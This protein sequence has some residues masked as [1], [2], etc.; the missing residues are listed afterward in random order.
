V[1]DILKQCLMSCCVSLVFALLLPVYTA[2]AQ[3]QITQLKEQYQKTQFVAN[4]V[5][6]AV[7]VVPSGSR[8]SEALNIVQ[9]RVRDLTGSVLPVLSAD[10]LPKDLLK[11][12][13][14]IALG[15]IATSA[16]IE[17][18]YCEW[19]VILDL[20]YPGRGGYVVRSLHN[21]YGTGKN[22]IFLGGSDDVG[23]HEAAREFSARLRGSAVDL[24]V[25]RLMTIRLGAGLTPPQIGAQLADW[26]VLSWSDSRRKTS[27]GVVTGYDPATYF[28]WN[29]ISVAGILYYMTGDTK[30]LQTF[31]ELALPNTHLVPLQN[32]RDEAFSDPLDPL[33]KSHHYRSHLVDRVF[34]LIEESPGFSDSERLAITQKLFMHQMELDPAHTYVENNPDRHALWHLLN[35][36]SGSMYF[37]VSYP[38]PVWHRRLDNVRRSFQSLIHDPTWGER[39]TLEWVSTS[40]E[41]VVDFFLMDGSSE[42]VASGTAKTLMQG[43]EALMSGEE[44]DDYNK[45]LSLG[46][47]SKA[48]YLLKDP[49]YIWMAQHLGVDLNVFRIGQS[50][51]STASMT[52][53]PPTDLAG[54]ITRVPVVQNDLSAANA[55]VAA[56]DAFQLLSYRSGLSATDDYWL[57]D[58]FEGLGR[59][60]FQLNT[61]LSLR[62]FGGKSILSGYANDLSIWRNGMTE[63]RVARSAALKQHFA[64][65]NFAYVHSAVPDM[66]GAGWDRHFVYVRDSLALVVD[67]V[68]PL[69]AGRFDIV[70]SWQLGGAVKESGEMFRSCQTDNGIAMSSVDIPLQK[71]ASNVVQGKRSVDLHP[72]QTRSQATVFFETA[73]P[74]TFSRLQHG[75]YLFGGSHT[76]FVA[77]GPLDREDIS[78]EAAFVY[79]DQK[80]IF[81]AHATQLRLQGDVLFHSDKPVNV[82]WN[83]VGKFL[84][85]AAAEAACIQFLAHDKLNMS[86]VRSPGNTILSAI[87]PANL[88]EHIASL[89]K[90]SSHDIA[91]FEDFSTLAPTDAGAPIWSIDLGQKL[92]GL[93]LAKDSFWTASQDGSTAILSRF[94]QNGRRLARQTRRGEML[95]LFPLPDALRANNFSV[96]AGFKDDTLCAYAEDGREVWKV[97]AAIHPS[98]RIGDHYEAPWFTNPAEPDNMRGILSIAVDDFWGNGEQLIALGRPC[99]VEFRTLNGDLKA[100]VPTR[101][102]NNTALA[103]LHGNHGMN[104]AMVL[105][106]KAY[107]GNPRLSGIDSGYRNVGDALFAA[108]LPGFTDMHAWLQRGM[109]SLQVADI[110]DDGK[111]EVIYTLS[112]HWNELRVYDDIGNPLWT[113]FFGPDKVAG[114]SS[115]MSA[116]SLIDLHERKGRAVI[117]GTRNGWVNAFDSSGQALWQHQV[118]GGVTCMAT[119]DEK[120]VLIVGCDDGALYLFDKI[121]DAVLLGRMKGSVRKIATCGD[122]MVVGSDQGVL[123]CYSIV[124]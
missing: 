107:T 1:F 122:R 113:K 114:G 40:I 17:R 30:Y 50:Y 74:A 9:A 110:N 20:K 55:S 120:G 85:V 111:D 27:H 57:L 53:Q 19:Q 102:G 77:S 88:Q 37:S 3:L 47:L 90:A 49:R 72:G 118:S 79:V 101:W 119:A 80:Q 28:G 109:A 68:N 46:L 121:G 115:F 48:S 15:N 65:N 100:S 32:S 108:I 10:A 98:F 7:I 103:V 21:P 11:T 75:G 35:I 18:L 106:G 123:S 6:E 97:T 67:Q 73:H 52:G 66:S 96:L 69:A 12:R 8:Y 16:F 60:P 29:P 25:D 45:Y 4:G 51:W 83:L 31:K 41:P 14:V 76:A 44:L 99:T 33:V 87:P 124:H 116:L 82:H 95:S 63:S 89:L 2:N 24:S 54:K 39:D 93:V 70:T 81:L 43:L 84:T 42:F 36:Y 23:V 34:D 62:M 117:V 56:Q 5:V 112:G 61:L 13:N 58:G 59:H 22:V 86:F 94:D 78:C 26:K 64:N 38:D 91:P 71:I 92:S 104:D 105:A